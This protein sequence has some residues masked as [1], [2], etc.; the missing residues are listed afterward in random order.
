MWNTARLALIGLALSFSFGCARKLQTKP[1]LKMPPQVPAGKLNGHVV[2][3][4][5]GDTVTVLDG[6]NLQ[7]RIRLQGIDAPES[8]QPFGT[9]SK[10]S[11]SDM[12]FDRD[13]TADCDKVDQYQPRG[14]QDLFRQ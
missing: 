1:P 4:A 9:Q 13:V 10:Q 11:L 5:D 7:H 3:I 14:V 6:D 2:R 12:I 8:H